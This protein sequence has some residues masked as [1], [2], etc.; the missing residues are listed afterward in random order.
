[1]SNGAQ[2]RS[3]VEVTA[4][5]ELRSFKGVSAK[6]LAM[7][8]ALN[9]IRYDPQSKV[10]QQHD[11]ELPLEHGLLLR[12]ESAS[13]MLRLGVEEW[14]GVGPREGRDSGRGMV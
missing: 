4:E 7:G 3:T 1:M 2:S 14:R 11:K 9:R 6:C 12:E 5:V 8:I 10:N 13:G